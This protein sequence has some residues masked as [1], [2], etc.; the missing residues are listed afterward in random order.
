MA[1]G[2]YRIFIG[3]PSDQRV[4]SLN[5]ESIIT[6]VEENIKSILSI[7]KS[8]LGNGAG[9]EIERVWLE[10]GDGILGGKGGGILHIVARGSDSLIGYD[11]TEDPPKDTM[12]WIEGVSKEELPKAYEYPLT[13][14]SSAFDPFGDASSWDSAMIFGTLRAIIDEIG[15]YHCLNTPDFDIT[16]AISI[17][18]PTLTITDPKKY[19]ELARQRM[20]LLRPKTDKVTTRLMLRVS[21][22]A[23]LFYSFNSIS[24]GES[25]SYYRTRHYFDTAGTVTALADFRERSGKTQQQVADEVG[26]SRRQ[27]QKYEAPYGTNLGE[28]KYSVVERLAKAVGTTTDKLV[29]DGL[30]VLLR[31][32]ERGAPK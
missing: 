15:N 26:M 22:L 28:A 27:L 18:Y 23:E 8:K 4:L 3:P 32:S 17:S 19:I 2:T 14:V 10:Y 24:D 31:R 16:E 11:A 29:R 1:L 13:E 21:E 9:Y 12:L 7:A 5:G 20:T 30:P 25:L 6:V